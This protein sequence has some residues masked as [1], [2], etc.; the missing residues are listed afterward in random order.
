MKLKVTNKQKKVR[1]VDK[2]TTT[3]VEG[4]KDIGIGLI[5]IEDID[6]V[7]AT[8]AA[9]KIIIENGRVIKED[10]IAGISILGV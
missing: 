9:K 2:M 3:R 1:K 10:S 5:W 4:Q 6:S 8:Q 7:S